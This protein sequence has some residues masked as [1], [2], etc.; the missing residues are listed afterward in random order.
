MEQ[1]RILHVLGKLNRGG[2]ETMVMNLY[3]NINKEKFQFDFIIHTDDVCEYTEEV[4]KLGGRIYSVPRYYFFNHLKYKKAWKEFFYNHKEYKIIHG[5]V[6]S[7]ASI[8]LKIAKKNRLT[9][10]SHSHSISS[11]KGLAAIIKNIFQ[12]RIRYIAD[13]FMGCSKKANEWLFG[14]KVANSEKC[15]V[16]KNGIEIEK[17]VFDF[18]VR[19]EIRNKLK[20][21]NE[22]IV[23]GHVGRFSP[24]KNHQLIVEVFSKIYK[25]N[26]KYKLILIGGGPEKETVIN[27]CKQNNILN[28]V[29]F[30]ESISNIYDYLQAM[31]IFIMPSKYEGLGMALIEAQVSGL[32]C[33]ASNKIPAEAKITDNV[34]FLEL[35]FNK[36]VEVIQ[37]CDIER[38][39]ESNQ[40]IQEYDINNVTKE[41]EQFYLQIRREG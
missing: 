22:D 8:Y 31:D 3:R 38:K 21:E 11:G 39:C 32:K 27:R 24:E 18:R 10:I 2:A 20:I 33:I 15:K 40:Y 29:I 23:I 19:E 36:W 9:T 1:Y 13:Y 17:F 30:L 5:H 41:L 35:D 25:K 26:N 37:K 16:I 28:N 12:Y 34:T 6:R 4:L 14:K 7:T